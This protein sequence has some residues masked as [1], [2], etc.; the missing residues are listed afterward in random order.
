MFVGLILL[1]VIG[2]LWGRAVEKA[3]YDKGYTNNGYFWLGFFGWLPAWIIAKLVPE[4]V[5]TV[6]EENYFGSDAPLGVHENAFFG[7]DDSEKTLGAKEAVKGWTCPICG[8]MNAGYAG[9]CSCGYSASEN[10]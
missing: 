8:K 6:Q 10:L 1:C 3:F 2:C 7:L 9:T 5:I 4:S